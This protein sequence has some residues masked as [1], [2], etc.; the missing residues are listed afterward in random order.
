MQ[1]VKFGATSTLIIYDKLRQHKAI[2]AHNMTYMQSYNTYISCGLA[3]RACLQ[4]LALRPQP[5]RFKA[6][7]AKRLS[8]F[9]GETELLDCCCLFLQCSLCFGDR[10]ATDLLYE[11]PSG[12]RC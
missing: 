3:S 2:Y 11:Q 8:F 6:F 10:C 4:V 9:W 12:Y 1:N 7:Q 5:F